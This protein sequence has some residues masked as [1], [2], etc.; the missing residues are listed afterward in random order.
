[1][2][3]VRRLLVCCALVTGV[4]LA[5]PVHAYDPDLHQQF[6][7]IAAKQLNRCL[8]GSALPRLTPLQVRYIAKSDVAQ[9]QGSWFGQF[10][11]GYY[12]RAAQGQR[13]LLWVIDTRLHDH[14]K[15]L[16]TEM[17]S[18]REMG[19]QYSDLGYIANYLQNMTSPAHV[20]PVY[21]TRWWRFSLSDR[22]DGYPIDV[23]AIDKAMNVDCA[24]L[25]AS[26][27]QPVEEVLRDTASA[28]LRAV[29]RRIDSLPMTWQSF[30][31]LADDPEQFGEYGRA[32][33]NFG[34]RVE[35]KCGETKLR[36]AHR[37]PLD[38]P[39]VLDAREQL[40]HRRLGPRPPELGGDLRGRRHHEN[41]VR[42]RAGAATRTGAS[43]AFRR[44]RSADQDRVRAGALRTRRR[45]T[46]ELA[47]HLLQSREQRSRASV[48][49]A[50][51][52]RPPR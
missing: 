14:F 27:D 15:Q 4:L 8:E 21:F 37:E 23:A 46:A 16:E 34:R 18:A 39:L 3:R 11:W 6:T 13:K 29:Q 20:V 51:R 22:F 48:R 44:R 32:G 33:N 1:M 25:L 40:R 26:P 24:A 42:W 38:G 12:D 9:A 7:F 45:R 5:D 35:L 2:Q 36:A 50:A 31:K 10:R 43:S 28:T 49:Y 19:D 47:L 30:W 52:R 17:S 41:A